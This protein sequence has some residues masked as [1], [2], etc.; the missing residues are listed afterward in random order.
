MSRSADLLKAAAGALEGGEDPFGLH[1]LN[2]HDVESGECLD[3]A[4]S[5][6]LG[7]R[8]L[9]WAMEHPRQAVLA[10]QGAGDVMMMDAVTRAL[11]KLGGWS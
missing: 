8:I 9:A 5:L 2:E 1:F 10:V 4:D 7:A 3:L 6:A 11:A